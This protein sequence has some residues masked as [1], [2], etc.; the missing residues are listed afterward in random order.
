MKQLAIW[1][2]QQKTLGKPLVIPEGER[3]EGAAG[4]LYFPLPLGEGERSEGE[5]AIWSYKIS[6]TSNEAEQLYCYAR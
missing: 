5:G 4:G 6:S 2:T 3:S 1:L